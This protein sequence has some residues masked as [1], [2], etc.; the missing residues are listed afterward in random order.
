MIWGRQEGAGLW[1]GKS[2]LILVM[3]SL[4]HRH[5]TDEYGA[6][7]R[8]QHESSTFRSPQ[9]MSLSSSVYMEKRKVPRTE[10]WTFRHLKS[11]WGTE[12]HHGRLRPN[13]AGSEKGNPWWWSYSGSRRQASHSKRACSFCILSACPTARI[14]KMC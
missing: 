6:P 2:G 10:L 7:W 8:S 4:T 12:S 13:H 1:R 5:Q 11:S 3:S 14:Q 9:H